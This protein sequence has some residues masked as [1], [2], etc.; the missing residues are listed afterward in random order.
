MKII[1]VI[2]SLSLIG[3]ISPMPVEDEVISDVVLPDDGSAP[4]IA[5]TASPDAFASIAAWLGKSNTITIKEATAIE[6]EAVTV[7]V[8]AGA[9]VSYKF[10]DDLG[11]FTFAKPLPTVKASVLGFKVSPS[12][13]VVT[14]KP[15]GSGVAAT[16][17]GK[18]KFRW[19]ADET[20]AAANELPEVWCYSQPGCPPCVRARLELAAEKD[21][22]FKVVW[23]DEAAPKWLESRP[24]FWWH[25]SK[26]QPSQADVNNTR[27]ATGWN[28]IRDF[29]ERWKNSR[30]PKKFQRS[31]QSGQAGASAR[32]D[33]SIGS[34][35][36]A[37][38]SINGDFTPSRSTL[39]THLGW[40]G[41]HRG[42]HDP[43]W[44]ETLTTE[45]LRWL[46]D[47]DHEGR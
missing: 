34:R 17:L 27:Q 43:I 1:L 12:L 45:Q 39:I 31:F 8:P 18:Y 3:C 4:S 19:L 21:L 22:P 33:H 5:V 24:A 29:I 15:D 32:P 35:S 20:A 47:R 13:S 7:N 9:T 37:H 38:W 26:D 28:G 36:V 42:R 11:T 14:L 10:T 6:Q 2:F 40:E 25:M 46:H 23:K 44:L 16:G 30:S 41:I